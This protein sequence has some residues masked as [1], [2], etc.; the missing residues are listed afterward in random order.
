M[1]ENDTNK[2]SCIITIGQKLFISDYILLG[3]LIS[4]L[5]DVKIISYIF[6]FFWRHDIEGR[7]F[8]LRASFL[9]NLTPSKTCFLSLVQIGALQT[10]LKV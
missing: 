2:I 10:M 9:E 5:T 1:N 3:E 8:L 6:F 4:K 7:S